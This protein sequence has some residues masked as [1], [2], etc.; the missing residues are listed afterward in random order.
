VLYNELSRGSAG[1]LSGGWEG[2][3]WFSVL[4]R[5][6]LSLFFAAIAYTC[7]KPAYRWFF[8]IIGLVGYGALLF[9][10]GGE[11]AFQQTALSRFWTLPYD[12]WLVPHAT[13]AD[14]EG[15]ISTL[16][17][18]FTAY[19]GMCVGNRMRDPPKR[20]M[21]WLLL[22]GGGTLSVGLF[23]SQ[24]MPI[25]KFLWTPTYVLVTTGVA[26][27]LLMVAYGL[28]DVLHMSRGTTF[29]TFI[30]A[31]SLW[32]Y[33]MPWLID[34]NGLGWKVVGGAFRLCEASQAV[35]VLCYYTLGYGLLWGSLYLFFRGQQGP[36]R[37]T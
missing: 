27:L 1:V 3:R 25:L 26:C 20:C 36:V 8:F 16:G 4:G 35:Q 37:H 13:V 10:L 14:P 17:A 30:G 12:G 31:H 15:V 24:V 28:L 9:A 34:F 32:F 22:L 23:A 33:F 6:G 7:L 29:L 2:V 19:A 18:L 5:I 11:A 21:C